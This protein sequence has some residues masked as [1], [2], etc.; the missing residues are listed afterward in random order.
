MKLNGEKLAKAL[1]QVSLIQQQ[2]KGFESQSNGISNQ[3]SQLGNFSSLPNMSRLN[4]SVP[5]E[6]LLKQLNTNP[7]NLPL[8]DIDTEGL[9][10]A[11]K[12]KK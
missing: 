6:G 9:L 3:L 5:L 8:G 1:Q 2:L 7:T 11:A 4:Q 12:D 10:K